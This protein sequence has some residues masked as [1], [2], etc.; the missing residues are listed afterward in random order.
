MPFDITQLLA[1]AW[2]GGG[3]TEAYKKL[4][5]IQAGNVNDAATVRQ[6]IE[7]H[8]MP[9]GF[10]KTESIQ[11]FDLL[12]QLNQRRRTERR[13]DS[14]NYATKRSVT[15]PER[16][17]QRRYTRDFTQNRL[18]IKGDFKMFDDLGNYTVYDKGDVVYYDGKS[19][20]ATSRAV[21]YVPESTHPESKWRP[22]DNPD[23]TID[24]GDTF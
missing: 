14:Y 20:I 5:A 11:I 13:I 15:R 17:S 21:G 2:G 10:S 8:I 19:Y 9:N 6:F 24:G 23:N 3:W 4:S 7:Q 18:D 22:I 12:S 16:R 1:Y